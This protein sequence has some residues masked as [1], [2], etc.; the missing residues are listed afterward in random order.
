MCGHPPTWLHA[1]HESGHVTIRGSFEELI[2]STRNC[3]LDAFEL[4]H[5]V[6]DLF[7]RSG[8]KEQRPSLDS[9]MYLPATTLPR[10]RDYPFL[11]ASDLRQYAGT[12]QL[13][14]SMQLARVAALAVGSHRVRLYKD[15]AFFKYAGMAASH[16]HQDMANAIVRP[17]SRMVTIWI[18][19][20]Q[21]TKA[22]GCLLYA[23]GSHLDP[24]KLWRAT[25]RSTRFSLQDVKE[26]SGHVES[27]CEEG[28]LELGDISIHLGWTLHGST[29]H[30]GT[31]H[32]K[33]IQL[34]YVPDGTLLDRRI[35]FTRAGDYATSQYM[36]EWAGRRQ[37]PGLLSR[38]RSTPL[39][40]FERNCS[41]VF[42][43]AKITS[44]RG[45]GEWYLA[46][47]GDMSNTS[48]AAR[49]GAHLSSLD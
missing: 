8:A 38:G 2:R 3:I 47:E 23:H 46:D 25:G 49:D 41:W 28:P 18:P 15:T 35:N 19:L 39:F 31:A 29:A 33:A 44:T 6:A 48:C 9:L 27:A 11:V 34:E 17:D 43:W 45:S 21:V 42:E 5:E 16:W 30:N 20:Q 40:K 12:Q 37:N 7:G 24:F 32:R 4:S 14:S 22:T 13:Y 10:L 26:F 1:L 36:R